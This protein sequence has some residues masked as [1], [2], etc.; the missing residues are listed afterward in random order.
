MVAVTAELQVACDDAHVPVQ[1]DIQT[2]VAAAVDQSG[3]LEATD[4]EVAVRVVAADEIRDLNRRYRNRDS[5]TNVL[6]FPAGDFQ[7]LPPGSPRPLG[8]IVVCASVVDEEARQQ[9]R[10]IA[11]HWAH[12]IVHG[13]LHLL[14]FDHEDEHEADAMEALETRILASQ[15]V[16]D[17][18]AG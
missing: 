17:P 18:Y 11:D 12:M 1:G 4:V 14:G 5:A 13:T 6:S 15:N 7:G 8:D 9:G 2:W 3:R 16:T 10:S